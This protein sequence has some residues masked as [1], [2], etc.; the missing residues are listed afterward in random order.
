MAK[1]SAK[2]SNKLE[3]LIWRYVG[4]V[5]EI[6]RKENDPEYEIKEDT[7]DADQA[8]WELFS[9]LDRKTKWGTDL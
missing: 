5:R 3:D 4:A 1:L 6:T 9:Y 7:P 2:Q 8:G